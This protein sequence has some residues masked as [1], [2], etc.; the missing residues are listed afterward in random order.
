MGTLRH[1]SLWQLCVWAYRDQRA[2]KLIGFEASVA[3]RARAW[4]WVMAELGVSDRSPTLAYDAAML[5]AEAL[6]LGERAA[7]TIAGAARSGEQPAPPT[8]L[9]SPGPTPWE[10]ATGTDGEARDICYRG[11]ERLE[12]LVRCG[13]I[14]TVHRARYRKVGR[15]RR[16][17]DG[18]ETV[19]EKVE[20]CPLTWAPSPLA[21]EEQA[22]AHRVW[23]EAMARL[24]K[25]VRAME[26]REHV[27]EGHGIAHLRYR[28]FRMPD[29][30]E[31]PEMPRLDERAAG[32]VRLDSS[33]RLMQVRAS[34]R[35][36]K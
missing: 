32:E 19:R 1:V 2:D 30:P 29:G 7:S 28:R 13:E 3:N 6:E 33:G 11:G 17:Q 23:L 34:T 14:V 16:V 15:N 36:K 12:Y 24:W 18:T 22:W 31:A 26:L 35:R 25:R 10:D 5:H 8:I 21:I 20:Y 9:P 27:I 4:N